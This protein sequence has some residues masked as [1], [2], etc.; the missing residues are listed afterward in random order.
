VLPRVPWLWALPPREESSG[1]ATCSSAPD[2]TSLPRW[3]SALPCGPGLASPRGELWSCHVPHDPQRVVN[4]R[5]KERPSCPRHAAGLACV[6]S[7]VA[8]YRGACKACGHAATVWF[9]SAM[10]AQLTTPGHG[11]SGDMT[12]QDGTTVLTMFSIAG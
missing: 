7:M 4:H 5:N 12:R 2:H 11:Y 8:C 1:A 9:N 10:Q 3:A 6:Q